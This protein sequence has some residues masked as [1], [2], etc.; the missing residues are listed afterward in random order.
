MD[1]WAEGVFE[2]DTAGEWADEAAG[3]DRHQNVADALTAVVQ[4]SLGIDDCDGSGCVPEGFLS[5]GFHAKVVSFLASD[6]SGW[7]TGEV[8][9]ASGGLR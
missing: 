3:S 1:A 5:E 4:G 6:D 7:L 8:I 2:N 9:L